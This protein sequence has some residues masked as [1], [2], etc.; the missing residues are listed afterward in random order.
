MW[1][2][3]EN[4]ESVES[5]ESVKRAWSWVVCFVTFIFLS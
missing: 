5:V 4:M 1:E 3:M 2:S